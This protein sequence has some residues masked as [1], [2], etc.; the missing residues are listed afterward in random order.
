MEQD[1]ILYSD[2]IVHEYPHIDSAKKGGFVQKI[3]Y[4]C[5]VQYMYILLHIFPC[6]S[7][8]RSVRRAVAQSVRAFAPKQEVGCS[9]PSRN[10]TGRD[11]YTAKRSAIGLSVT[12]PTINTILNFSLL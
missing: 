8:F 9:N 3:E 12:G 11:S 5:I 4:M 6:D 7:V 2:N 1:E 10:R